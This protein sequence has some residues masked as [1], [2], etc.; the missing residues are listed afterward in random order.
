TT[1]YRPLR[2]VTIDALPWLRYAAS[3]VRL[4]MPYSA[5]SDVTSTQASAGRDQRIGRVARMTSA[6]GTKAPRNQ[7]VD[8][9]AEISSVESFWSRAA[10]PHRKIGASA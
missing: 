10:L 7:Q 5:P 3:K 8:S 6:T 4:P 9:S 1:G 2:G